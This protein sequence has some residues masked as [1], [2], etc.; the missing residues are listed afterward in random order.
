METIKDVNAQMV[1]LRLLRARSRKHKRD[2]VRHTDSSQCRTVQERQEVSSPLHLPTSATYSTAVHM[3]ED[4]MGVF[5][6]SL[7]LHGTVPYVAG[8][9]PSHVGNLN[10]IC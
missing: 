5:A 7:K 8:I 10:P 4:T 6:A 3:Y 2:P 9:R 1:L